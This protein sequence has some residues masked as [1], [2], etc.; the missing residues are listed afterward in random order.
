MAKSPCVRAEHEIFDGFE[1]KVHG[2]ARSDN[3]EQWTPAGRRAA[4]DGLMDL[5]AGA[6]NGYHDRVPSKLWAWTNH[7]RELMNKHNETMAPIAVGLKW[8]AGHAKGNGHGGKAFEIVDNQGFEASLEWL[9]PLA[10]ARGVKFVSATC[11]EINQ[12]ISHE[13]PGDDVAKTF[14]LCTGFWSGAIYYAAR[15]PRFI[16]DGRRSPMRGT[17]RCSSGSRTPH[18]W[19]CPRAPSFYGN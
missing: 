6:W 8:M 2:V 4:L 17:R 13:F 7:T 9:L 14:A 3:E 19:L 5:A 16:T 18:R 11:V 1:G 15:F 10:K 12:R